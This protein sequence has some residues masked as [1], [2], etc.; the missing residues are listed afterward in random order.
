MTWEVWAND[1]DNDNA[2]ASASDCRLLLFDVFHAIGYAMREP[3]MFV[4][5]AYSTR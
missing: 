3:A 4:E 2:S 5:A 1:N